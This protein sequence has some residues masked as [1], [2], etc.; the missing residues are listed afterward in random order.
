MVQTSEEGKTLRATRRNMK[1]QP[2]RRRTA[3]GVRA[4]ATKVPWYG[5][6]LTMI[7]LAFSNLFG[8]KGAGPG[9]STTA[10]RGGSR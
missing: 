1:G 6:A 9:C 4:F 3:D 10:A 8:L 2:I 5:L 7:L